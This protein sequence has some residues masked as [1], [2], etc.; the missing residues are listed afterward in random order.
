[1][2][3]QLVGFK[4]LEIIKCSFQIIVKYV[5]EK[6]K[7]PRSSP[8]PILLLRHSQ[9]SKVA[10]LDIDFWYFYTFTVHVLSTLFISVLFTKLLALG[11]ALVFSNSF[12]TYD[13][14]DEQYL[15]T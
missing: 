1:M 12:Y 14:R 8:Y 11:K 13:D 15:K 9:V 7:V 4:L 2:L 6:T 5:E 10:V 3:T